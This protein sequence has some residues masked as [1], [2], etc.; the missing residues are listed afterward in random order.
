MH[1]ALPFTHAVFPA[2]HAVPMLQDPPLTE[3]EATH[4]DPQRV[5]SPGQTPLQGSLLPTHWLL[6]HL[7][8]PGQSKSHLPFEQVALPPGGALHV[9]QL[10]PQE[11]TSLLD[12]QV[13]PSQLWKPSLQRMA[14]APLLQRPMP[15]AGTGQG[16]HDLPQESALLSDLQALFGHSW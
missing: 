15:L 6:P 3:L 16:S 11:L 5:W 8:P 1:W 13:R 7:R 10:E 2:R 4:L 12:L 14:Q 9:V